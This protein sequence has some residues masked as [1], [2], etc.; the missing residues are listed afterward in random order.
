MQTPRKEAQDILERET[1]S[2]LDCI[3]AHGEQLNALVLAIET[4][5]DDPEVFFRLNSSHAEVILTVK[6]IN[7]TLKSI[8]HRMRRIGW[9]VETP[10]DKKYLSWLWKKGDNLAISFTLRLANN[11]TCRKVQIGTRE[12]PVYEIQC[13]ENG[14]SFD[15]EEP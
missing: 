4:F 1:K 6:D 11:A 12:V 10:F 3:T 2:F 13:E 7:T 8:H 9:A 14:Q 5:G 15:I